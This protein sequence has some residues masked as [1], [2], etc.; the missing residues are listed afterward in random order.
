MRP[1]G[2][3][4]DHAERVLDQFEP[5]Q[6]TSSISFLGISIGMRSDTIGYQRRSGIV[7]SA[8]R[9]RAR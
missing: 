4:I 1:D 8:P 6:G 9:L 2:L 3:A 5:D 7:R